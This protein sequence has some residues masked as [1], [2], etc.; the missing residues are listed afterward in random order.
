[1]SKTN[2]VR[3][4]PKK[5]TDEK[6]KLAIQLRDRGFSIIEIANV[7]GVSEQSFYVK[8]SDWE[9]LRQRLNIIKEKQELERIN[10]VENALYNR[11]IGQKVKIKKEA[12]DQK[13]GQVVELT[14]VRELAGDVKAQMFYLANRAPSEWKLQPEENNGEGATDNTIQIVIDDK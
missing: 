3:G 7:L 4:R 13:T 12:L 11:A 5:L 10:K 2:V 9:R 1:M 8:N 6:I 14:E